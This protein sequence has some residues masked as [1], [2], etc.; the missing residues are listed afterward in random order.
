MEKVK[1]VRLFKNP[2]L[3]RFTYIHPIVPL[4][5]WLPISLFLIYQGIAVEQISFKAIWGLG[6]SAILCWTLVEYCLHRWLFHFKAKSKFGKFVIYCFH[7]NHHDVPNDPRRLVMP[8]VP[9]LFLASILYAFFY[10]ALGPVYV[11]PFFG[12]FL[13]G[14]LAYDYIHFYTH[15]FVPK[16]SVGIFLRKYHLQHHHR[17]HDAKFGVSSPL[18]D[19]IF[20][21]TKQKGVV[22]TDDETLDDDVQVDVASV[23]S[24]STSV[25][26]HSA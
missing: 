26:E 24:K 17:D 10:W 6:F 5:M 8:P 21:T 14:Y 20:R 9:G 12:F 15:H 3:E 1:N 18:W 25:N 2:L 7:G 19:V 11:K 22:D 23:S 16:S 13:L 4:L